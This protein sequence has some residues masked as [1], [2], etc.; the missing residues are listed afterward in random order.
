M[1]YHTPDQDDDGSKLETEIATLESQLAAAKQK[2]LDRE[3]QHPIPLRTPTPGPA[4]ISIP[5]PAAAAALDSSYHYLLLLSDSALPLGSF[6]F[7]SG[8]ES[9]LAHARSSSFSPS[10]S[11]LPSL[12][13]SSTS[14]TSSIYKPSFASFL[15]LSLSSYASTTLPFVLAAHRD[16]CR[17]AE[18]DDVLDA[19]IVCAVGRRASTAQGRAL[20]AIWEKS[21]AP[22]SS[23]SS[24]V[25]VELRKSLEDFSAA[26]RRSSSSTFVSSVSNQGT[27]EK[28]EENEEIDL[29]PP[30]VSAHLG[31]LFGAVARLLGLTL[32][33]TAYVF[34]LS[35]AKALVSAAV[36]A[37]MFGPY[38]AQKVLAGAALQALIADLVS[39][40]WDVPVEEAGQSVPVMDLWI[41]RHEML[42]SRIFNS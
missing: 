20:L 26:L 18:L 25:D 1:S 30:A 31:P 29:L 39:R 24:T 6:A 34:L 23:S 22:S 36:R 42:Y 37:S 38:Q 8:L 21:L 35:H 9:Y 15:P 28:R 19:S 10:S 33:Q 2:L 16:P 27:G 14:T 12:S 7:S 40:E 4:A 17:V 5:T 3:K 41:G 32:Q 11:S 13:S